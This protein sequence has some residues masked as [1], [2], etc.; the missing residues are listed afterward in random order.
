MIDLEIPI[1]KRTRRYRFFEIVPAALSFGAIAVL[2]ILSFVSPLL[3][4]IYLLLAIITMLVKAVGIAYHTIRGRSFSEKAQTIEWRER[5]RE[6]EDP[7]A[8]YAAY[9]LQRKATST[10]FGEKVHREN[11]RLIAAAPE[12]YPRPSELYNALIIAAYN[13]SYEVLKATLT[14]VVNT[15]YDKNHLIVVLAYEQR[16][17]AAMKQRAERLQR[18]FGDIFYAFHLV[19]HPADLP[20]EVVGKGGNITYAGHFLKEWLPRV[21]IEYANVIVTT[22]DSDNRPHPTYFDYLTYEYIVHD[23]RKHL[24][25]QPVALFLNN[26]WDVPAPMRVIATGNSFWN[27]ISSMRPH[28]LRNFA[29]HAQP[30][31][32]LVEMDFWST[33]TIV[34]D[35]HQYWRS[36]FYF[37]G[38]Y[39]DC[40]KGIKRLS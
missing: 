30:M 25:Y 32:A 7:Q 14:S 10:I 6:L 11:L 24:A 31:D 36:F 9:E 1:G 34:E 8:A 26:I 28:T 40:I 23:D 27:I 20:N 18:E 3:A 15:T 37:N 2:V 21:G 19:E 17:G 5:L 22:L 29:S 39:E 35:G 13:E 38:N 33:R 4:A 12:T 16:G